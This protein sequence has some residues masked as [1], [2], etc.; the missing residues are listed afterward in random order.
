MTALMILAQAVVVIVTRL[1]TTVDE[2]TIP[3]I[4]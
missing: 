3:E 4:K 2:I 1:V